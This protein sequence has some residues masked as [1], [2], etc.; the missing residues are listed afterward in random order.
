LTAPKGVKAAPA[1]AG[2]AVEPLPLTE[3]PLR[4]GL[5]GTAGN[6]FPVSGLEGFAFGVVFFR[7]ADLM[8]TDLIGFLDFIFKIATRVRHDK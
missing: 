6:F 4:P 1:A 7:P 2:L 8:E 3:C 5:G